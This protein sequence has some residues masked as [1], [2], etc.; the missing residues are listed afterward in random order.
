[1][2][3]VENTPVQGAFSAEPAIA[4]FTGGFVRETQFWRRS[5]RQIH[6]SLTAKPN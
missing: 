2:V 5:V 4:G 1:M 6:I 3:D